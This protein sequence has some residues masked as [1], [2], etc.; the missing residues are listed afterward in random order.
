M[1]SKHVV[2]IFGVAGLGVLVLVSQVCK[3][4][5]C[6]SKLVNI[7]CPYLMVADHNWCVVQDLTSQ[8]CKAKSLLIKA[9]MQV[10]SIIP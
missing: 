10:V 3:A 5:A 4:N 1:A 2:S 8:V 7:R 9:I 6:S